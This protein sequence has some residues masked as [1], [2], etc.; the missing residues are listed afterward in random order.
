MASANIVAAANAAV[1]FYGTDDTF[2]TVDADGVALTAGAATIV[3]IKVVAQDTTTTLYYAVT[4]NRAAATSSSDDSS[5][6]SSTITSASTEVTITN[7][8]GTTSTISG[9]IQETTNAVTVKIDGSD[10]KEAAGGGNNSVTIETNLTTLQFD[11]QA[12]GYLSTLANSKD[13]SISVTKVDTDTLSQE[14]QD[15]IGGR[16]TYDFSLKAGSSKVSGFSGG[17]VSVSIPYT[18]KNGEDPNAIVIYYISESGSLETMHGAYNE[19]TGKVDFVTSHFSAYCVGYNK[20]EF[21]DVAAGAWYSG[22]VTFLTARGIVKGMGD[23]MFCP[24]GIVTRA[25]FVTMLA[26]LSGADLTLYKTSSFADVKTTDWYFGAVQWA[27]QNGIVM[28]YDGKFCPNGEIARQDMAVILARYALYAGFTLPETSAEKAF[29]DSAEI[30]AYASE[31]AT[32]M[33]KSNIISGRD[34]GSFDPKAPATRAEA[35]K[36]ITVLAREMVLANAE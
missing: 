28:G 22:A 29:T 21:T 36:M 24:E 3:Y 19:K 4:I 26:N 5:G 1:T 15:Q 2:T 10:F 17:T 32:A 25:Q 11:S 20:A 33:Q 6:V 16:P 9:T 23:E 34:D 35:A 14:L 13:I 30:S 31:A 12:A 8:D 18:L 27:C 7:P